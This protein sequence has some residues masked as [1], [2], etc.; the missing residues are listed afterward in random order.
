MPRSLPALFLAL[1][2]ASCLGFALSLDLGPDASQPVLSAVLSDPGLLPLNA[3]GHGVLATALLGVGGTVLAFG[4]Q[5]RRQLDQPRLLLAFGIFVLATGANSAL[6]L[7]SLFVPVYW[8]NATMR[9]IAGVA[10]CTALLMLPT[11][12]PETRRILAARRRAQ[13]AAA[14]LDAQYRLVTEHAHDLI[15]VVDLLS[16]GTIIFASP[17]HLRVLE[18]DPP[19]LVGRQLRI[20][21]HPD[22]MLQLD[23]IRPALLRSGQATI[24]IRVVRGDGVYRW[25]EYSARLIAEGS[26]RVAVVVGR[27]ITERRRLEQQY[28]QAQKMESLG[29]LA[30][31]IA[32]DLNNLVTVMLGVSQLAEEEVSGGEWPAGLPASALPEL[33]RK[34]VGMLRD[35]KEVIEAARRAT[36]LTK[37]ILA[38][39]R[40]SILE[41]QLID[42]NYVVTNAS[43][44]LQRLIGE[45][46][47]LRV[48]ASVASPIVRADPGQ[49]EQVLINLVVNA[50]DS[51]V[52][53]GRAG[54]GGLI[55]LTTGK[56]ELQEPRM[57]G[58]LPA[59]RYITLEVKDNGAGMGPTV[60]AH[61]FEPFYTTKPR[62]Q[63]TGLGLSTCYGIVEQHGGRITVESAPDQGATFCIWLPAWTEDVVNV[64]SSPQERAQ[65]PRGSERVLLVEDEAALRR[66]GV[67][68]LSGLGYDVLEASNG[69][70]A[71]TL[72]EALD[73][74]Q[75]PHII[76]TDIIMPRMSGKE[77]YDRVIER[78]PRLPVLFLSGY[79]DNTITKAGIV[80]DG[81]LVL[82]KP[83]TA[84]DLAR[85]VRAVL[86]EL[87]A[88]PRPGSDGRSG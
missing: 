70:D 30:G 66:F 15:A 47:E 86:D 88:S 39:A 61:I 55:T 76:C 8:T 6:S 21:V 29:R 64:L 2:V 42:M 22:D 85:K 50:R 48:R 80:L 65:L 82:P 60:L 49:V 4:Y 34:R 17:S 43:S 5:L 3:L 44:M 45:Q 7:V 31:G 13:E 16:D 14:T 1:I 52:S 27:D 62:G 25:I 46:V 41:M 18:L 72:L 67:R 40:Q 32:H 71:L 54:A 51:I 20:L 77:L 56:V 36:G 11:S 35:L 24:T 23:T 68:V 38:F 75:L 12:V 26:R 28:L 19:S 73:E 33:E 79:T 53:R 78:W 9:L 83:F 74:G 37:Q 69:A 10:A 81:L 58:D 59:G 57:E 63:G 87:S 84:V